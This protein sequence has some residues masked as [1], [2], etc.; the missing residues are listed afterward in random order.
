MSI[1]AHEYLDTQI[2]T[3]FNPSTI[4]SW[5][6]KNICLNYKPKKKRFYLVITKLKSKIINTYVSAKIFFKI[7]LVQKQVIKNIIISWIHFIV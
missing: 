7:I 2:Y 4:D 3:G 5:N 1:Q 6:Y